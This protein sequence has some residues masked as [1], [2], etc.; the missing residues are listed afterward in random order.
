MT[1]EKK[2]ILLK[3]LCDRL[4][5]GVLLN[6]TSRYANKQQ[7]AYTMVGIVKSDVLVEI[8]Y[9]PSMGMMDARPLNIPVENVKPYLRPMS[10]MTEEEFKELTFITELQYDQLELKDWGNCC[11]TL[12]FYLE[13]IPHYC[14]IKVFDW[15]NSHH[16]DYRELIS[17]GLALEAPEGMYCN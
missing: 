8:E 6:V 14:V 4:P 1:K 17:M 5:H 11:K 10:S 7:N 12:E 9:D 15:L 3:D 13:E 16:F 2:Q